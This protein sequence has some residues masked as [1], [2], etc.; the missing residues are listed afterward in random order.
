[1]TE[2]EPMTDENALEYALC[3]LQEQ[4][5]HCSTDEERAELSE[6]IHTLSSMKDS[7]ESCNF[8][9]LTLDDEEQEHEQA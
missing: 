1:M 2:Q 9:F 7:Y 3:V 5:V 8:G 4:D 6:V